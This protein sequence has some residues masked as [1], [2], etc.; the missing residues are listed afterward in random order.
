MH[1]HTHD[2]EP[3]GLP[4]ARVLHEVRRLMKEGR[5]SPKTQPQWPRNAR[6]RNGRVARGNMR[7]KR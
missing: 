1:S 5:L 3:I 4:S 7:L 6:D 2:L